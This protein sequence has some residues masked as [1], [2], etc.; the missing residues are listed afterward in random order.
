MSELVPKNAPP[1]LG[2][3]VI[4]TH[5]FD[6]DLFHDK[7][8]G[9]SVTGTLHMIN[10]TPI[11]WFAKKQLTVETATYGSEFVAGR[12]CVDQIVDLR[13]T[14]R[15]LGVP[16]LK[17]YMF[18]D[19]KSMVDSASIPDGK[20]HKRHHTLSFHRVREAV[21]SKVMELHHI[22]GPSNPA[23]IFTKHWGYQ[24]IWHLL[25]PIMFWMGTT[26][27]LC[28]QDSKEKKKE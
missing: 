17:G 20:L 11:D 8:T 27:P 26:D 24:Q 25:R 28:V 5:Y 3:P 14:L 23:D 6:A 22:P 10:K 1:A 7:T 9:R 12:I 18:G 19:N 2:E 15:Y 21:A 4:F 13:L 16:T